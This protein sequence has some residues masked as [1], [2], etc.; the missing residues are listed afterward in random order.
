M[1]F[2]VAGLGNHAINRVMPV[3]REA[4]QTISAVYSRNID[5]ARK[6]GMKYN[7]KPFDDLGTFFDNGE[8][9]AVYIASPNFLH[10]DQ[11]KLAL[12]KGKHVLLEKQ[13]TLK[14]EEAEELVKLAGIKNLKL[15]IGF[16]MRFHPA[17][18]E[19]RRII[20]SGE[21]GEVSYI[22][23]MWASLSARSYD[24]PDNKWWREDDKVGGGA[25]MG[26]GVHVM[27]TINYILG[28]Y[29]DRL[30]S[31]RNPPGKVIEYTEHVTL[32]YGP[33][34]VDIVASREM[35][36]PMNN[37]TIYGTE[38]TIVAT[39]V[40]STSVE[41]SLLRDGRKLKDFRGVNV[42]R[43][44]IKGFVDLVQ[45]KESHIASAKDG[46]EVVRLVNLAFEADRD[47]SAFKL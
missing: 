47:C 37:L 44:E 2:G 7:A 40:F 8:F 17:I 5:K 18:R 6:E 3:F 26:T 43:E 10:Y 46:A 11:A 39:G 9:E 34:I 35:K 4:G 27:D 24:D 29:P 16:H 13:M 21:L 14:T 22:T 23:G 38:G 30:S 45:G 41:S 1:N 36:S 28:K 32:Q 20:Q 33:T 42:Y 15:A 31:F 12:Q 19:A 25:V